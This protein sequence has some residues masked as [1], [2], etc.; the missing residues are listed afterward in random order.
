MPIRSR[1]GVSDDPSG[2]DLGCPKCGMEM[3]PIGIE[4]E[5]LP[6]Q[7]LQL[8]PACYLVTWTD[9]DGP[10]LRQGVPVKPGLNPGFDPELGEP[11]EC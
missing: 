5:G 2:E 4:A 3:E 11:E 9:Q 1:A 10:H 7:E 8:C 6:F